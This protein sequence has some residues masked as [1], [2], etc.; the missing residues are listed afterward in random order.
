MKTCESKQNRR[1]GA[2]C[3]KLWS[4]ALFLAVAMIPAAQITHAQT[5][6]QQSVLQ[7]IGELTE[8]M[9]RTQ[10]LLEESQRQL[11]EMRR[12]L[13]ELQNRMSQAEQGRTPDISPPMAA[14]AAEPQS[15]SHAETGTLEE[16]RER[17]Q[18]DEAQI[19]THEQTKVE[20]ESKYPVK[21]TGLLLFSGF[22]NTRAV[23]M[24][25][26]PTV[27]VSGP[28]STG[29]SIRQTVLGFDASGPHLFGA[30]SY[31][32]FRVD[33]DGSPAS[34]N[35]AGEYSGDFSSGTGL[36]RLRTAHAGLQWE[37]T[38]AYFS[39]DRP[40]ISPDAPTS[41]TAVAEPPLAW[42]GNLWTWN[43]QLGVV[44]RFHG[45]SLPGV[46][47]E[48]ALVDVGDAPVT[49]Q[50]S[51]SA[52]PPSSAEQSRW[53]GVEARVAMLGNERETE[54]SHFGLGGFF[55]PHNS[56]LGHGFDSWAAT[57]DARLFLPARMEFT[58]SGYRG[59]ALGGLGGGA[60]KDIAYSLN[61]ITGESYLVPLD[62]AG[63]WAQL[64]ERISE[65][66]EANAAFG[67]D[68]AFAGELLRFASAG[69]PIDQNLARNRTF[70]GNFIYS[71]SAFLLFSIEYR[72]LD[73]FS[74]LAAPATSNVIGLGAGYKF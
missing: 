47:V 15:N 1:I 30:R 8:A 2:W 59:A 51:Y 28:G 50:F 7:Q 38:N 9:A 68:N 23:D 42:S 71:P 36:I 6:S 48:A 16:I 64:K 22:V 73:S 34:G 27:A 44:R 18:I 20:S 55:A 37:N 35:S 66:L 57:A 49:P 40:I 65:R 14:P 62:D 63:G 46:E 70:T 61:P 29:A 58:G 24:A 31:A 60:F 17:Q 74:V 54:R 32:D 3:A 43:P 12:K 45:G 53:P 11:Q 13:A 33:F 52:T 41:L 72:R 67:M 39:L 10:A 19:A 5:A 21:V 69:G 25:S 56:S 4:L 26:T